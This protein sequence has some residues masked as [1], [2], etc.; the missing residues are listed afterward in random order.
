L[1]QVQ[2]QE[3]VQGPELVQE[4]ELVQGQVQGQ[5]QEQEQ[6]AAAHLEFQVLPDVR[7]PPIRRVPV[8]LAGFLQV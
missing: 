3:Q 4:P 2:V 5:E 6:E 1:V 8:V 7:P